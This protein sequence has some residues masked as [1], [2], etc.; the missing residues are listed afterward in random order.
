MTNIHAP[1][2]TRTRNSSKRVAVEPHLTW[3]CQ[4]NVRVSLNLSGNLRNG[5][6]RPYGSVQAFVVSGQH[7]RKRPASFCCHLTGTTQMT[8]PAPW[9]RGLMCWCRRGASMVYLRFMFPAR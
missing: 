7:R 8:T 1:D 3:P 2:G 4:L 6:R 9:L 5:R